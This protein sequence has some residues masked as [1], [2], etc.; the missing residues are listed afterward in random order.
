M[1]Q[2]LTTPDSTQSRDHKEDQQNLPVTAAPTIDAFVTVRP[3]II[4]FQQNY[5]EEIASTP[6]YVANT[7]Y[8]APSF[9]NLAVT[10]STLHTYYIPLLYRD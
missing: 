10:V 4:F 1:G 2:K 8:P 3:Q 6:T 9:P 5:F 7:I